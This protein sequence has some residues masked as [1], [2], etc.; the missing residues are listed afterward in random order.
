MGRTS[1]YGRQKGVYMSHE[2]WD[3][4]EKQSALED[5]SL[6]YIVERAVLQAKKKATKKK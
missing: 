4:V 1:K 2:A 3:W 6:N 5:R